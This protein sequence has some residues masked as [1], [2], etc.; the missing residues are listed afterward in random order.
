[1]AIS[2]SLKFANE[3][4]ASQARAAAELANAC[5][6]QTLNYV[7][8]SAGLAIGT[9][10]TKVTLG[11][12]VNYLVQGLN[13]TKNS[14]ADIWTLSGTVVAAASFQSYLLMLD[15]SGTATVQEGTQSLVSQAKVTYKNVS[16][17]SIYAPFLTICQAGK[18]II[19][20]ITVATDATHTFT[21]GTTAL[22]AT[23]ITTTYIN[24]LD[25]T[26]VPLIA[27]EAGI[28][29]GVGG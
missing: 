8:G 6:F 16:G 29:V 21:P 4:R 9:T 10:T 18:A 11:T 12:T 7:A 17:V 2:Y 13:Y 20:Y 27:N 1:M 24:G 3:P 22:S 26:L 28:M 19:G 23:G 14:G 5:M 15:A 25:Q